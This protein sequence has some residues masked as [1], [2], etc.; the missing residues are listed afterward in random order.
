MG[1]VSLAE[2]DAEEPIDHQG[3]WHEGED[4]QQDRATQESGKDLLLSEEERTCGDEESKAHAPE[5]TRD[6]LSAGNSAASEHADVSGGGEQEDEA[7][8]EAHAGGSA[9]VGGRVMES[10]DAE[11]EDGSCSA[12]TDEKRRPVER[13]GAPRRRPASQAVVIR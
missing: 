7:E 3:E 6:A 13:T 5:V 11:R 12:D 2:A 8:K 10:L 1:L 9:F 4:R